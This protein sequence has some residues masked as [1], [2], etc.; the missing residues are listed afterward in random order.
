MRRLSL[1]IVL[2]S[3]G[4]AASFAQKSKFSLNAPLGYTFNDRVKFDA[5]YTDVAAGFQYG[6][7]LEFFSSSKKSIELSYQRMDTE[8]PLYGS[9]GQQLNKGMEKAAVSYILI[10]GNS[11]FPKTFDAKTAPFIGAGLG[12]G[13]IEYGDEAPAKFA[14]NIKG[15]VKIKTSSVVSFK[16]QAYLQSIISTFGS[17]YWATGGGTVVAVPDYATLF[18]FGLGGAICIDFP[19]KK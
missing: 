10:G 14:W 8:M 17:D 19:N 5:A 6:G 1:I 12:V 4:A 3:V 2:M 16:L 13:I 7:S 9:T 11:Y 18:Q 15:G